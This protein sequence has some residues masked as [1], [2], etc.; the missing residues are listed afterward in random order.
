MKGWGRHPSEKT[1]PYFPSKLQRGE[2]PIEKNVKVVDEQGNEYEATYLKRAKGL[3]KHGRALFISEDTICLTR[4]PDTD[5]EDM[6]MNTYRNDEVVFQQQISK[7]E[8]PVLTM[9]YVLT[10]INEIH[11]NREVPLAAIEAIKSLVPNEA[12]CDG[13]QSDVGRSNA[14]RAAVESR[15]ETN[16]K[17]LDFYEKMYDYLIYRQHQQESKK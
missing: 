13:G 9:E 1:A 11:E 12:P 10:K 5:L 14:I 4:P 6:K 16:R 15:E 8:T 7:A 2:I 17:L 3:V